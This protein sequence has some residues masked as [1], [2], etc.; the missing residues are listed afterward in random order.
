MGLALQ[1]TH[2]ISPAEDKVTILSY[3]QCFSFISDSL[4]GAVGIVAGYELSAQQRPCEL[5]RLRLN[6]LSASQ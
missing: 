6:I 1:F 4:N 5:C 2:S 3:L